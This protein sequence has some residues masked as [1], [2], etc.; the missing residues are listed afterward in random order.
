MGLVALAALGLWAGPAYAQT[1]AP[2]ERLCD[3]SFQDCRADVLTYINQEK[4]GIDIG[5]WM[6]TD[7][8][9]S[10][11]LVAA[12][13]R[14][15]RVRVL[16]DPRCVDQHEACGPQTDQ[17]A[18]AGIPMRRRITSGI[19]HWKMILFAGQGQVEF[20]G[21]NY[22]P[23]EMVPATP[24]VNYTDEVVF[25]T[26]KASLVQSFMTEFD[27]L[28]TST[29]EFGNYAN[30]SG[31]LVRQYPTYAI[32]P[33]LNLPPDQSYRTRAINAY[34]AENLKIDVFMFRITDEHHTDAMIAAVNRGVPVRLLTD[35]GEYRNPERLWDA[36]NVDKMYHGGVQV[37]VNAH[38]GINHEKAVILYGTATAIFGSSNWTSPSSDTQREHNYFTTR[39]W[40]LQ[41]L[42]QQ[43]DRKWNNSAG[44]TET[45]AFVPLPP[46]VP[47]YNTPANGATGLSTTGGRL[48]WNA[49]LWAHLY[50][51]YFGTSSNP[52]LVAT[53]VKLGPSQSSTD[54]KSYAL[55]TLQPGTTYYW[56]IVSKT[57]AYVTA[58]GPVWSF[59]TSGA[60]P[61]GGAL[62]SGWSA[63][64]VGSTGAKGSSTYSNGTFTVR[65]AGADVWGTADAF[66]YAYHTLSGDG[67]ITARVT[68][69]QY[70]AAWAKAGV[71]MR[72]SLSASSA[73]AF[74][75]VSAGK[76]VA[77]QRRAA[78][79]GTA[80]NTAGSASTAPRWVRLTRSGSTITAYESA[81]GTSWSKV[82]S[83]T[84][85][86]GNTIYVGLA[87]SS[88]V[89]G[90]LC[91]AA[92]DNV[93]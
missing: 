4:V 36:Y 38:Q 16:M 20:G 30:V 59:T 80:V 32:D 44:Y 76:G 23:F 5:Y 40:I 93:R 70:T 81:D 9:Y 15:V 6:I 25:Y 83:D 22:A 53:N 27:T 35:T 46:D 3:P 64:D 29:S 63:S 18:A 49:G 87:V 71:M 79:G 37:R 42:Q 51:I 85:A 7:A 31:P 19:L 73:N 60:A 91:T 33:A 8:R 13:Q 50:D 34:N 66:Q 41:W 24:Y 84:V 77:F 78:D 89:S 88:H 17:L 86:F 92:F 12:W 48:M 74:M 58:A 69:V 68:S 72:G 82:G 90:T 56:K 11:A 10:N 14:G 47:V 57:M 52:P 55:P 39:S 43:F 28:W 54:Y 1:L 45:K 65:G 61:V 62:P 75:L 21:A 26:N 67:S 2:Q